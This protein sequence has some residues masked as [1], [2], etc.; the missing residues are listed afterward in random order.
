MGEAQGGGLDGGG[1][2]LGREGARGGA[3]EGGG[4][5]LVA[6]ADRG[7]WPGDG[8]WDIGERE[9]VVVGSSGGGGDTWRGGLGRRWEGQQGSGWGLAG[10]V[11]GTVGPA[12]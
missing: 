12:G 5:W 9:L 1:R 10:A 7:R 3:P 4:A 2:G 8:G 6:V 11:G